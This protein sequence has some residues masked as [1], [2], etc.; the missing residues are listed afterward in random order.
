MVSTEIHILICSES[1]MY[2]YYCVD[3]KCYY[4]FYYDHYSNIFLHDS[5]LLPVL[6]R[7]DD[8]ASKN[9]VHPTTLLGRNFEGTTHIIRLWNL[10]CAFQKKYLHISFS[11]VILVNSVKYEWQIFLPPFSRWEYGGPR[12][13]NNLPKSS[14][15]REKQD[16]SPP[17]CW[18]K[19]PRQYSLQPLFIALIL[20][21][22]SSTIPSW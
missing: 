9:R 3:Y 18:S 2:D 20:N 5:S 11:H 8:R 19:L 7:E 21:G 14:H 13:L 1:P 10:L 22:S 12:K 4:Y 6:P 16:A 17:A 15:L